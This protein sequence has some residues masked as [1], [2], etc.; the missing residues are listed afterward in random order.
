MTK[1]S[2]KI[3]FFGTENYSL[4]V[5]KK[6]VEAGIPIAYVVTK[7]DTRR[8]R[9]HKLIEPPVKIYAKKHNIP[10][11]QPNKVSEIID[12]ITPLKPAVGILVAYGK[13]IPQ[14]V[15]DIFSP[16]IINVHPSLL[17]A[18]R[19]PSPI[20][21]AMT[22]LDDETG[23][24]IMQLNAA[25]DAGPIYAQSRMPLTGKETKQELYDTLFSEGSRLLI[26]ALPGIISGELQPKPQDDNIATYCHLLSKND[27]YINPDNMT[28]DQADA[29]VRAY[30]GFPRSRLI[31]KGRDIIITK[32]HVDKTPQSP[33]DACC[34]DGLWLII[35]ELV[36]PSGKTMPIDAYLRGYPL[37][38]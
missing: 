34:S 10:V 26:S 28:A 22:N 37:E 35:D 11:L 33:L 4:A 1:I 30:L 18:Y 8:G 12:V 2:Q 36:A 9:G 23:V 32:T 5:L 24:S 17:P 38:K 3:V 25:M 20:E 7:P 29:H 21:A 19:G 27:S 13:I 6:L 16:G 15:I 31:V 14:S